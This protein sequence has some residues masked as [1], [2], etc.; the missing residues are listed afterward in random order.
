MWKKKSLSSLA[1]LAH[2]KEGEVK[3]KRILGPMDLITLGIGA[4]VGAGLFSITGI[5]AAE[6]AGPAIVLS[7]I[8]AAIGCAFAGICYSELSCMIPVSGSAYTYT[9]ATMGEFTA[10]LMGWNLILEYAIGAATVS[11]S[12]SAYIV[13]L[14]HDLGIHLPPLLTA[15]PWQ[16]VVLPDGTHAYGWINLPSLF[17]VCAISYLLMVGVKESVRIN[18][19]IVVIKVG[20]VLVFIALG[21]FYIHPENYHPFIPQN[22][23]VFGEFGLSGV[24]RAAAV[25][26]FAYIGFDAVSTAAQEAKNPQKYLPVGIL[27]SLVICTIL[28]ILFALVLT[29]LVNYQ[30]LNVAAPV[31]LAINQTP[32]WWIHGLVKIAILSGL[33]SVILVFL[34]AQ[35]RIFL[36]MAKDHM[37]P[38][39]FSQIHPKYQT[40]WHSNLILMIFVGLIGGFAPLSIVGHMTSIGTLLAFAMV[41]A[42][43][44][45]LRYTHPEYPR[46]FRTPLVPLIPILGIAV[47]LIMMVSL[48]LENWIRLIVWLLIGI[49]FYF[50]YS[51]KNIRKKEE[52]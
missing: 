23:G 51:R 26:F 17:I 52:G 12:W 35:S 15:S 24:V 9:Y 2:G 16:S 33:T 6:N 31:A 30:E 3:L 10:W 34:L 18:N 45:I 5:A 13:S 19:I 37:I 36:T 41:C 43:V 28:Y 11:I 46:P 44:M 8:I 49:I 1:E 22:T 29:G 32:F 25:V 38:P 20:V 4:I 39:W 7:F 42:S 47:C 21:Y 50:T 27:G 40:P 14:L 48:G